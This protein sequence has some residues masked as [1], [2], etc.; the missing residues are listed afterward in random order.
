VSELEL[1]A[2]TL[3]L[4]KER[5]SRVHMSSDFRIKYEHWKPSSTSIRKKKDF[6]KTLRIWYGLGDW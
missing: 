6:P 3:I 1:N 2:N 5:R 4:L